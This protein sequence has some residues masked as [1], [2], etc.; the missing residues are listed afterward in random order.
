VFSGVFA[1]LAQGTAEVTSA[2]LF[3]MLFARVDV[4][5][6]AKTDVGA[7]NIQARTLLA[8]NEWRHYRRPVPAA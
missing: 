5:S 6:T 3:E 7:N 2:D 1:L 8:R 4:F